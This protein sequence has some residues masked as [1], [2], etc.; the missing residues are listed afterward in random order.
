L[1][2]LAANSTITSLGL[3]SDF[4]QIQDK[5]KWYVLSKLHA[6]EVRF[7]YTGDVVA[8][9]AN[10]VFLRVQEEEVLLHIRQATDTG[11]C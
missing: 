2:K 1:H 3:D 5:M 10:L 9:V 4:S 6:H 11:D 8:A 7:H